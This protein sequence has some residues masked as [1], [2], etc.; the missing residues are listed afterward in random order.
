MPRLRPVA[1]RDPYSPF[2]PG[3]GEPLFIVPSGRPAG[4]LI[5]EDRPLAL[6]KFADFLPLDCIDPALSLGEGST[7][8][9]R[10]ERIGAASGFRPSSR[11][12]RPKIPRRASRTAARP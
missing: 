3:C 2:C 12:T 8:L 1:S 10:L 9:I 11:R 6:E 7:P 5:H 4:R